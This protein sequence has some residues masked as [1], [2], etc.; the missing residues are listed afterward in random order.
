MRRTVCVG[1][2]GVTAVFLRGFRGF[3]RQISPNGLLPGWWYLDKFDPS[4][5]NAARLP[6]IHNMNFSLKPLALA[7]VIATCSLAAQAADTIYGSAFTTNTN[8]YSTTFA[9]GVTATFTSAPGNFQLKSG[10]VNLADTITGVGIS[11][12]TSGEIDRS[13]VLTGTFSKGV[14]FSSIRLGLLFD[15]PEYRDVNE[16]AQITAYWSAGGSDTFKLTAVG[17]NAA[18]W[19]STSG[20]VGSS[21]ASVGSGAVLNGTGA[22]DIFNPFGNRLVTKLSFTALTGTA[23]SGC[24]TCNNQSDYTL[25]SVTAV[26][27]VETYALMLA[28]LGLMGTIARRRKAKQKA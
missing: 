6:E 5:I 11:G 16:V 21:V 3:L 1:I 9:D 4:A 15:G 10:G 28:G 13:E 18:Q 14:Q 27:E 2:F 24:T 17:T 23:A 26:P 7:A 20:T 8:S 25:V 22:W 19:Y 12:A